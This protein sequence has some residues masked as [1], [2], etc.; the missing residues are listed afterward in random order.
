MLAI[1]RALIQS[2]KLL[3]FDEP[4]LGLAP[5]AMKE[6]FE[7]I[8]EINKKEGASI[9]I[10]EQNVKKA[11]GIADRVCILKNGEIILEEGK[12]ILENEKIKNIYFGG[13]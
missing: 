7:K 4:S 9:I 13:V 11:V 10:V 3:L 6:V 8:Q 12:E 1:G 2:P 5:K